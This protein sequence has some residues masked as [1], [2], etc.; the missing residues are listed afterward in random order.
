LSNPESLLG[1][2]IGLGTVGTDGGGAPT[3]NR[4]GIGAGVWWVISSCIAGSGV[5][6]TGIKPVSS[7]LRN[8]LRQV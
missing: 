1:V 7:T 4:L 6:E 2:G 5:I 3:V 8:Y